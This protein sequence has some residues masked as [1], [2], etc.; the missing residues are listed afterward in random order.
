MHT[1]STR[2]KQEKNIGPAMATI[3]LVVGTG[4]HFGVLSSRHTTEKHLSMFKHVCAGLAM[5]MLCCLLNAQMTVTFNVDMN[6]ELVNPSGI[7]LAGNFNT[8]NPQYPQ[9][10]PAGIEMQD[11][12]GDGVFSATLLLNEGVYEY[13]YINGNSWGQDE[14][15]LPPA[16]ASSNDLNRI[17]EVYQDIETAA[18]FGLCCAEC[19]DVPTVGCLDSNACNFNPTADIPGVCDYNAGCTDPMACNFDP[20][21]S[22]DNGSCIYTEGFEIIG[23]DDFADC[24]NWLIDNAAN[25]GSGWNENVNWECGVG[26]APSGNYAIDPLNSATNGNGFIMVDSDLN[27]NDAFCENTWIQSAV[28]FDCTSAS[29]VQIGFSNLYRHWEASCPVHCLLEVSRDG[30]TWPDYNTFEEADGMVDF[31]DGDGPV[32]ARFELFQDYNNTDLT[33]NPE[34]VTIDISE[35]ADGQS[36]WLRFRWV[37]SWGYAWMIDDLFLF[38]QPDYD[39]VLANTSYTNFSNG[40]PLPYTV[41]H[42]SQSTQ[43]EVTAE[44][45]NAGVLDQNSVETTFIANSV[46][47]GDATHAI[48]S[49]TSVTASIPWTIPT[50]P[51]TYEIEYSAFG[52]GPDACEGN[53]QSVIDTFEIPGAFDGSDTGTG[54]QYAK[55]DGVFTDNTQLLGSI[56]SAVMT[57]FEFYGDAQIHTI[58]AAMIGGDCETPLTASIVQR[59]EL[60]EF[61]TVAWSTTSVPVPANLMNTEFESPDEI[62]WMRFVFDPPLDVTAGDKYMAAVHMPS[63]G[64]VS[65]GLAQEGPEPQDGWVEYFGEYY[66]FVNVPMIRFNLDPASAAATTVSCTDPEACNYDPS[67]YY[68]DPA[69]CVYDINPDLDLIT[70]P[71]C[72][73]CDGVLEIDQLQ[74]FEDLYDYQW[75]TSTGTLVSEGSQTFDG[76]CKEESYYAVINSNCGSV[77]TNTLTV[78]NVDEVYFWVDNLLNPA[79]CGTDNNFM[80]SVFI[81]DDLADEAWIADNTLFYLD[82]PS[83]VLPATCNG[84]QCDGEVTV[85]PIETTTYTL[86]VL[87]TDLCGAVYQADSTFTITVIPPDFALEIDANPTSGDTPLTVIFDNQTPN[88]GNYSFTWDFGDGT[89][90]EDNGSFVQHTYTSGGIW[91]VTLIAVENSTG[92]TD[93]LYNAE[94]I[95]SIGDGCP[96]GCTDP[97]A[98]NYDPEAECDDGTC[99]EFDACGECGGSGTLGCMDPTACNYD[100]EADCDDDLCLWFDACGDCGGNGVAGCMDPTYCNYN[101]LATCEDGSC[102][103]V[104]EC[105]ECGGNGVAGCTDPEACNYDPAATCDNQT[106][107]LVPVVDIS[108]ANIVTAFTSEDYEVQQ[109]AD[110]AYTWTV[111]GGV[112]EGAADTYAASVFWAAEGSGELCVSV[113]N[114]ACDPVQSCLNVVITPDDTVTGCTDAEACNYNPEASTDNG[115]CVYVGDACNDGNIET[116]N[117]TVQENC[118]CQ[119]ESPTITGCTDPTACNYNPEASEDDGSCEYL[120][121][122]LIQG[123]ITPVTFSTETYTYTDTEGSTYNWEIDGGVISS[124]QGTAS[125]DVVWSSEGSG[126]LTGQETNINGCI[127]QIVSIDVVILPT[128]VDEAMKPRLEVYPNPASEAFTLQGDATIVNATYRLYNAR[129]QVVKTGRVQNTTTVIG[130]AGIANGNYQL[131]L[132]KDEYTSVKKVTILK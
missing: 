103:T 12:D 61:S 35:V 123:S 113:T 64:D 4:I 18:C 117:D 120:E 81:D 39:V 49:E 13:K 80:Y 37:G 121:T 78:D 131:V 128:S 75:F 91:D 118:E 72:G 42:P 58:Q 126:S 101:P 28:G 36:V 57:E 108:G 44:V 130:I 84:F 106:C 19:P 24:T 87:Y 107:V 90:V 54:G 124:G 9:W 109:L 73:V 10:D 11:E 23:S 15:I 96:Q 105:G 38:E 33:S 111:T 102:A 26:L 20:D 112:L 67:G 110:A 69:A 119:G 51:N 59:S 122:Y 132:F 65:V 5:S 3:G 71:T 74:G 89:V 8:E 14:G 50:I 16:C 2:V 104:D 7:H 70:H 46:V 93:E 88:I 21:Y 129:G 114:S 34:W 115:N 30:V 77:T 25:Y 66:Y 17:I 95:W 127:G 116:I 43:V 48:P 27:G 76:A 52:T 45:Y 82:D 92:C 41:W 6:A 22:C 62:K 83:N 79:A 125:V 100:P 98:C 97:N 40:D 86:G 47:I 1:F 31:G 55:D 56:Y 53:N 85:N 63:E 68:N 29:E 94:F 99:L 60:G 32:Q